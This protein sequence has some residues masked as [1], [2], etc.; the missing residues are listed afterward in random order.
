MAGF[1]ARANESDGQREWRLRVRHLFD[2][3]ASRYDGARSSYPAELV[4]WMVA[5]ARLTQGAQVLEIGCGTGQLTSQLAA[6][7]FT[8]T[9]IDMG[10]A[11]IELA[12][13]RV[14][15]PH[16]RFEP[17]SFE[18]F[19]APAASFDLVTSASAFHWLDPAV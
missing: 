4:D 17:T 15:D 18:D 2:G 13:A 11:M 16:V 8:V 6:R 7:G 19:S 9:A 12:R 3:V 1:P 10:A 14:R 5:T